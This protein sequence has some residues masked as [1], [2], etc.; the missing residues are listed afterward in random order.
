MK[1]S[2]SRFYRER[3]SYC[4][5][6]ENID[7]AKN[8]MLKSTGITSFIEKGKVISLGRGGLAC[9]QILA[10]KLGAGVS[11]VDKPA[12]ELCLAEIKS[13][14]FRATLKKPVYNPYLG[15]PSKIVN[16][17]V[18]TDDIVE[19]QETLNHFLN[20]HNLKVLE[21]A[22]VNRILFLTP[23]KRRVS[24]EVFKPE[25]M[26]SPVTL[27]KSY[28]ERITHCRYLVFPWEADYFWTIKY[29]T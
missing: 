6:V 23:Y 19:T 24:K 20:D 2:Y 11:I 3:H 22:L 29:K 10:Y 12:F 1:L 21:K 26:E 16:C 17:I 28:G 7:I 27:Y 5:I 9:A 18:L 15:F 4:K 14:I 8:K 25:N 13:L